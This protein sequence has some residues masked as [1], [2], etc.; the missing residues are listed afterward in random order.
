MIL[1]DTN[2]SAYFLYYQVNTHEHSTSKLMVTITRHQ[3]PP[4]SVIKCG[5]SLGERGLDHKQGAHGQQQYQH[6]QDFEAI[7]ANYLI[8]TVLMHNICSC[9]TQ[10]VAGL[11]CVLIA[12]D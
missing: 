9:H 11:S 5:S 1:A 8:T 7:L 4:L 2:K 10:L 6:T 3:A 12:E